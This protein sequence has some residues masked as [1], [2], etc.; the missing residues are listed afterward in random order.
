MPANPTITSN[1]TRML[2][3]RL[4]TPAPAT[5]SLAPRRPLYVIGDIHGRLDLLDDMLG[6]IM[7]EAPKRM[8]IVFVG[9][10]VDRG[11]SSAGV[12]RALRC[13]S[14]NPHL[15]VT[16]LRGNHEAMMLGF[17]DAPHA[18]ASWLRH[19]GRMTLQSYGL[20]DPG[21]D[22]DPNT[23][24]KLRN[25]LHTAMPRGDEAFL[26]HLPVSFMSG[27]VFVSHAGADPTRALATQS[28]E[29]L[30]WG[31]STMMKHPRKD[32]AWVVHGH[33]IEDHARAH[34]RRIG[35]DTGAFYTNR[36][37]AAR[38]TDGALGILVT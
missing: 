34:D 22:P 15:N 24:V 36:L 6:R 14:D 35:V 10:Y 20:S 18:N 32:G 16:C 17:L 29:A 26:R 31:S 8:D 33:Y 19:G 3:S 4:L 2:L 28:T 21:A 23:L 1:S 11:P 13:L 27:N 37:S 5:A 7:A 9:D 38:I 25:Q 30:L 12:I